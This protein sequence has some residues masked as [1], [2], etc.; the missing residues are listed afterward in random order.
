MRGILILIGIFHICSLSNAQPNVVVNGSFEAW[1]LDTNKATQEPEN[2][3]TSNKWNHPSDG[4]EVKRSNDA[5][6]GLYSLELSPYIVDGTKDSVVSIAM[7]GAGSKRLPIDPYHYTVHSGVKFNWQKKYQI[8]GYYKF[9]KNP[10]CNDSVWA[11][12]S[13]SDHFFCYCEVFIAKKEFEES[14][15]WKPF[16]LIVEDSQGPM[17]GT[18]VYVDSL[19]LFFLMKSEN[20]VSNNSGYFRVDKLEINPVTEVLET[21][22]LGVEVRQSE[23]ND[24][25]LSYI[26]PVAVLTVYSSIGEVVYRKDL[27]SESTIIVPAVCSG[28]YIAKIDIGNSLVTKKLF[29]R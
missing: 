6:D 17:P 1:F 2:W 27:T 26:G 16:N 10:N 9:K 18:G 29:F 14:E 7:M 20:T 24:R 12:L 4:S 11:Y 8:S 22:D 25:E 3:T 21:D 28:V 5:F 19:S 15:N 23:T 13:S